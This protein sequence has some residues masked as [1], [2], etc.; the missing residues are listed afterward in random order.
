MEDREYI[1]GEFVPRDGRR[2]ASLL[3]GEL[4]RLLTGTGWQTCIKKEGAEGGIQT[5]ERTV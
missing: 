4:N 1:I 3:K 2:A 5:G